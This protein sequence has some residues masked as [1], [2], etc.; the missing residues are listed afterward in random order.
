MKTDFLD[1]LSKYLG[2]FKEIKVHTVSHF[3]SRT[4]GC[5]RAL[6]RPLTLFGAQNRIELRHTR[7]VDMD[8]YGHDAKAAHEQ[9]MKSV[10][11]VLSFATCCYACFYFVHGNASH[12]RYNTTQAKVAKQVRTNRSMKMQN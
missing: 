6:S 12:K 11:L 5:F 3:C 9:G 4:C 10:M 1:P 7:R 8:R 2:Q